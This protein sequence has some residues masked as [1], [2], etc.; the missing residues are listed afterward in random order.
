VSIPV[1]HCKPFIVLFCILLTST[2]ITAQ[3]IMQEEPSGYSFNPAKL[4]PNLFQEPARHNANYKIPAPPTVPEE[5]SK[6]SFNYTKVI[7]GMPE[8]GSLGAYGNV[9][10]NTGKGLPNINFDL[11]TLSKGGVN[12][13]ISISYEA[14]GIKYNDV[15]SAVGLKWNLNAGGSI[16]RSVNGI[17]DEDYLV[18]HLQFL[19]VAGMEYRNLHLMGINQQDSAKR[20]AKG[21]FDVSLDNYY[22]NF[23]GHSGSMYLGKNKSFRP[24]KEYTRLQVSYTNHFDAFQIKDDAGNT[25]IFSDYNDNSTVYNT[26]RYNKQ[27]LSSFS[28]RVAWKLSK[29]I[30]ATG[31]EI[32]FEYLPYSYDYMTLDTERWTSYIAGAGTPF[33]NC[34]GVGGDYMIGTSEAAYTTNHFINTARL[35][36]KI[37]TDD[38]EVLFSYADNAMEPVFKRQLSAIKVYSK[39]S[40]DTIK[41]FQF[42]HSGHD[43]T[44]FSEAD[45]LTNTPVKT[46]SFDYNAG[47]GSFADAY[48]KKRDLFGYYNGSNNTT[49][50]SNPGAVTYGYPYA[51]A[52]RHINDAVIANGILNKITY[53]TGGSTRFAYEYNHESVP[54]GEFYAPGVRVKSIFDTDGA[55]K[56]INTKLF[57]YSGLVGG[58]GYADM[59]FVN[60]PLMNLEP[61]MRG[62]WYSDRIDDNYT[63]S[64]YYQNVITENVGDDGPGVPKQY[65][66]DFYTGQSELYQASSP[67]LIKKNIYLGDMLHLQK[68]MEYTYDPVFVDSVRIVNYTLRKAIPHYGPFYYENDLTNYSGCPPV[69]LYQGYDA[70]YALQP[71]LYNLRTVVTKEYPTTGDSMITTVQNQYYS[72]PVY[73]QQSDQTVYTGKTS[74]VRYTYPFNYSTGTTFA[75]EGLALCCIIIYIGV[76]NRPGIIITDLFE[77]ITFIVTYIFQPVHAIVII[78]SD[79]IIIAAVATDTGE[80]SIG[81]RSHQGRPGMQTYFINSHVAG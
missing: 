27:A 42:T 11:Y 29:I 53:P 59:T 6:Y 46:H 68:T 76:V 48:D 36:S 1:R 24:D 43:L 41:R 31:Q 5:P 78:I 2:A 71:I 50:M 21:Q 70:K 72:S 28:A 75:G 58:I 63:G 65:E 45:R 64:F 12:V 25:Y 8:A 57:H 39:I 22:Y 37:Y 60:E 32:N 62:V 67:L 40:G 77:N 73:L 4:V 35:L 14:S 10:L 74:S 18:D 80:R 17:V 7:P 3:K 13:P 15:P 33:T 81:V 54:A 9:S 55:G 51:L 38:Q 61:T 23:P 66:A 26:G 79:S 47:Y 34:S 56:L 52:D 16:N 69:T 20:V 49:L 44:G 19:D 30:T